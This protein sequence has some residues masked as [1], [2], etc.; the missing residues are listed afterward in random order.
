MFVLLCTGK[1][2]LLSMALQQADGS[3]GIASAEVS[4]QALRYRPGAVR[5]A[6]QIE[7]QGTACCRACGCR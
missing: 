3:H 5:I 1:R 6:H 7:Q 2:F 4:T